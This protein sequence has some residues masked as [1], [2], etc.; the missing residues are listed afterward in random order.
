MSKVVK[1]EVR[2]QDPIASLRTFFKRSFRRETWPACW[3]R[4]ISP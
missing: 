4:S 2:D 1:I 3:R